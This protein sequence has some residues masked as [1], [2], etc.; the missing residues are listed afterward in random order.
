MLRGEK[1]LFP[2]IKNS[3]KVSLS[4]IFR[5]FLSIGTII[6]VFGCPQ[7]AVSGVTPQKFEKFLYKAKEFVDKHPDQTL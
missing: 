7:P 5:M 1:K 3:V 4:L 2:N 6:L